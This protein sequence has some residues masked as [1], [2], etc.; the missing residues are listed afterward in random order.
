MNRNVELFSLQI[1][2]AN[3]DWQYIGWSHNIFK[4]AHGDHGTEKPHTLLK[5]YPR[6]SPVDS[7]NKVPVMQICFAWFDNFL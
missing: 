6:K 4:M 1:L 3:D 5:L 7:W 2:F